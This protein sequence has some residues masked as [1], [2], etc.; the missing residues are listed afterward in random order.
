MDSEG[1]RFVCYGGRWLAHTGEGGEWH[2]EPEPDEEDEL[3]A[4]Q[5]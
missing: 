4:F 1:A 5:F 3:P 2:G